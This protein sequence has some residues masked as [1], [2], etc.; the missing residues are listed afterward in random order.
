MGLALLKTSEDILVALPFERLL[1]ALNSRQ[2]PAFS[3][4]P[5]Q[6]LKLA[7][8]FR[9]SRRLN[10]SLAEYRKELAEQQ[11]LE[12]QT[13]REQELLK[14]QQAEQ[15]AA[16]AAACSAEQDGQLTQVGQ[17][18]SAP[19]HAE[20]RDSGQADVQ[21]AS[22][23]VLQENGHTE[24]PSATPEAQQPDRDHS[25]DLRQGSQQR[26]QAPSSSQPLSSSGALE[27][28]PPG[29]PSGDRGEGKQTQSQLE[30]RAGREA[31]RPLQGHENS[32]AG[33][34]LPNGTEASAPCIGAEPQLEAEV[35]AVSE[36][37]T[38]ARSGPIAATQPPT[39]E[40]RERS[41][42][43]APLEDAAG[44][45]QSSQPSLLPAKLA[46][47]MARQG[48][49]RS[50]A[51]GRHRESRAQPSR[52]QAKGSGSLLDFFRN[53]SKGEKGGLEGSNAKH[54]NG[55]SQ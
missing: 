5:A 49:R 27:D 50:N 29:Q 26:E 39:A 4:P 6:L 20:E 7:L 48:S 35:S 8:S 12:E 14:Q 52:E 31:V 19:A 40:G 37:L 21:Q 24:Q 30:G 55:G 2:F 47:G 38:S 18:A 22:A 3:R 42:A 15:S 43:A 11:R 32:S 1:T 16:Q 9:V 51:G 45:Q 17:P 10:A 46:N 36:S 53:S 34:S 23:R 44:A 54:L 41:D 25:G 33:L 13:E 28:G